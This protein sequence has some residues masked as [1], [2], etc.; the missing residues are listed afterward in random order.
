MSIRLRYRDI[1]HLALFALLAS[2]PAKQALAYDYTGHLLTGAYA[3]KE[4]FPGSIAGSK[5]NDQLIYSNRAYLDVTKIGQT[6][7]EFVTDV[8]DNH[9]FFD[10][11]D[12]ARLNLSGQNKFRLRLLAWKDPGNTHPYFWSVGRFLPADNGI[13]YNDG[14]E[15]GY[16]VNGANS[17]GV[18]AGFR[19]RV[20]DERAV[21]LQATAVQVG[22]YEVYQSEGSNWSEGKYSSNMLVFA[23]RTFVYDAPTEAL[24]YINQSFLHFGP[25]DRVNTYLDF[26]VRPE[27]KA[28]DAVIGYDHRFSPVLDAA[29]TYSR[30][31]LT[32]YKN[33][34]DIFE[35]LSASSYQQLK[36]GSRYKLTTISRLDGYVLYGERYLD[37]L[38]KV[39]VAT[40]PTFTKILGGHAA[41]STLVGYRRNFLSNDLFLNNNL[42]HYSEV[43]ELSGDLRVG[44]RH[45]D[46]G[47]NLHPVIV[48]LN[49]GHVFSHSVLGSVGTEYAHNEKATITSGLLTLGYRFGNREF[50]PI[51]DVAPP[52]ERF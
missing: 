46:S 31:D 10:K 50:A 51:R 7:Y 41:L 28:E 35:T 26:A 1:K 52:S 6:Q 19:P 22:A 37:H 9:D 36:V 14:A 12:T 27:V 42:T 30:I 20:N 16:K 39:E 38:R 11:V 17:V 44:I 34:R 32:E 21:E 45:Q 43:W 40:G 33:H 47:E 2:A 23:P 29:L 8:R 48:G 5:D 18:F 49:V 4:S 24:D 13:I 25:N 3:A 15:V